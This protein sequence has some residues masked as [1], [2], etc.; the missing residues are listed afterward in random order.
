MTMTDPTL[1][2]LAYELAFILGVFSLWLSFKLY[3]KNKTVAADAAAAVKKIKRLKDRRLETLSEI[4]STKYGL[5]DQAL[6][7]MAEE[8]HKQE[9]EIYKLFLS[10][11]TIK[12]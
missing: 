4:L 11:K 10:I 2:L 12:P 8:L 7:Q 5:R 6:A 9:Q 1:Q 3:K